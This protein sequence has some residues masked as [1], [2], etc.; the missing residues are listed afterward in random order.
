MAQIRNQLLLNKIA[1]RLKELRE[2]KGISQEQ[3]YNE[4]EVHIARLETA[5]VNVSISTLD[6][7]CK[8]FKVSLSDFFEGL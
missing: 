8:Y 1:F 6:K 5:K 2:E 3:L 4:T 7:L